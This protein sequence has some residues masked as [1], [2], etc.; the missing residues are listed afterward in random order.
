M[1]I[2]LMII[3]SI[4]Y[5][6]IYHSAIYITIN[7]HAECLWSEHSGDKRVAYRGK[8]HYLAF[9]TFFVGEEDGEL[10]IFIHRIKRNQIR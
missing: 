1:S 10:K 7:G 6:Y 4:L 9:K 5:I 3:R 8:E 2:Q